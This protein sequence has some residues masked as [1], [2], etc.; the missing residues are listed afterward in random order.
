MTEE[1][2]DPPPTPRRPIGTW[3]AL[4]MI[5]IGI[6]AAIVINQRRHETAGGA[7]KI[8][9]ASV[10]RAE[11][12]PVYGTVTPFSLTERS[13]KTVTLETML[14]RVWVADYFFTYCGGP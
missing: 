13:G 7:K 12:L 8:L 6:I 9:E 1:I 14:G 4:I 5:V 10:R 3:I 2:V 11:D